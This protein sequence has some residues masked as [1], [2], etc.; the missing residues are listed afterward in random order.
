MDRPLD[1][2]LL[3][4]RR[5]RHWSLIGAGL[6]LALLLLGLLQGWVEP[7]VRRNRLRT[8][9]VERGPV[10]ATLTATGVVVPQVEQV[11]T[12]P[13]DTRVLRVL[14]T[15]GAQ[16][17]A[18]EAI[19]EL[20][21]GEARLAVATLDDQ[22][23]LK[24]NEQ[25]RTRQELE[26]LLTDVRRRREIKELELRSLQY[27]ASRSR[28][29]YVRGLFSEDAARK[30]ETD[31]ERAKIELQQLDESM[32][33]AQETSATRLEGLALEMKILA[34]QRDEA[35][36]VLQVATAA[37]GRPGILTW[38]IASEGAAVRRGDQIA[39]VA[40]LSSF[41][42]DATVS[43]VHAGRLTPGLPATVQ[44]GDEPLRGTISAVHPAVQNG[45]LTFEVA[46]E[47]AS[48]PRLRPNLRVDVHAVTG[49][50][51]QALRVARGTFTAPDGLTYAFVVRGD[52]AQRVPIRLGL[53]SYDAFEIIEGLSEG[54]EVIVS[55]T[56]D[57]MHRQEVALR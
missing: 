54:D 3:A 53:A 40:D 5:L 8:A 4:R 44:V 46:L 49:S 50:K 17:A 51:P 30:A 13:I 24:Q 21:V 29:L 15:P 39:R 47:R 41:R 37:A 7:S 16:L 42:V 33:A 9:R 19:V 23:A 28:T 27:E 52:R 43:D 34:T 10:E 20:D 35:A 25:R 38:V 12:S 55:D 32:Q 22:V 1:T 26:N 14:K 11:L 18:G 36:H 31:V 6:S 2:R 56:S 57:Y 45:V 48:D